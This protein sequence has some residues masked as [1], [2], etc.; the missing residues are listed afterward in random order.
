MRARCLKAAAWAQWRA[1][2]PD[3]GTRM[4]KERDPCLATASPQRASAG[5]AQDVLVSQA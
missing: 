5:L 1:V 3:A 4:A 2:F